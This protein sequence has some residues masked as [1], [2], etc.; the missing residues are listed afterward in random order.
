MAYSRLLGNSAVVTDCDSGMIGL[1]ASNQR[2]SLASVFDLLSNQGTPQGVVCVQR[3]GGLR[4]G[5]PTAT[6]ELFNL[7]FLFPHGGL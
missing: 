5:P 1:G 2:I 3:G 7:T 4:Y 6:A